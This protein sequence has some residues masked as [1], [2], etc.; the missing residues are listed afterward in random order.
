VIFKRAGIIVAGVAAGTLL[1]GTAASAHECF[2]ASRSDQG[3]AMATNSQRWFA[4]TVEE[5][6]TFVPG[7][8]QACFIDY[9]TSHG[10]PASLTIRA[11]KTIGEGSANPNLGNGKGID[12][13]IDVYEGLLEAAV[14][15]CS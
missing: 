9:W 7:I 14:M 8:D 12:H 11:D 1:F 3:N 10:G 2:N 13:A 6:A 5:I 15:A 4:L